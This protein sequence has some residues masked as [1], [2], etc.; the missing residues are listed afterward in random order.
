M[1]RYPLNR[2]GNGPVKVSVHR[3]GQFGKR[4]VVVPAD[5]R[6]VGGQL[7][8]NRNREVF[9]RVGGLS[10]GI[11][12]LNDVAFQIDPRGVDAAFGKADPKVNQKLKARRHPR[13]LLLELLAD[14]NDLLLGDLPFGLGRLDL[15][16]CQGNGIS[17][18]VL[19]P[20][21]LAHQK[22]PKFHFHAGRVVTGSVSGVVLTPLHE[23]SGMLVFDLLGMVNPMLEHKDPQSTPEVM[24]AA[25]RDLL[26]IVLVNIIF[27]PFDK[28][29]PS[30]G[31]H[32]GLLGGFLGRLPNRF[33]TIFGVIDPVSGRE[34][35]PASGAQ[36]TMYNRPKRRARSLT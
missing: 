10:F 14:Q 29:L 7:V 18:G 13:I 28:I 25:D 23:L 12:K 1:R 30:G 16:A 27:Y 35:N 20:D 33:F 2:P 19:P 15:N 31:T 21:R 11:G 4:I 8:G 9:P 26:A 34:L 3:P 24:G 17:V 5:R 6:K 36:V 32:D 22:T